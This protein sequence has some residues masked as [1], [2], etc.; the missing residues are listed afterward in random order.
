MLILVAVVLGVVVFLFTAV[1]ALVA[2]YMERKVSAFMQDRLG[3]MEVGFWGFRGGKRFWGGIAQTLADTFKLLLKEDIIPDKSDR[4]LF[5]LGPFILYGA[6]FCAFI[7][8]PLGYG[9]AISDFNIGIFYVIA[10]S[11]VGVIGIILS[12]W[13]SNN[14]WSLYG[15]VRSAAQIISYELPVGMSL[16]LVVMVVGSLQFH[17]IVAWQEQHRWFL[18]HSPFTIVAFVIFFLSGVAEANRTPFDI[19]EAESELVAGYMTEYSGFRWAIFFLSEYA[20]MAVISLMTA[21]VFLG[22]WLSPVGGLLRLF[23]VPEGWYYLDGSLWGVFWISAK[24]ILFI[25][26]MMWFRWTWPRLR[27]DQLMY[28]A[29]KVFLPIALLNIFFVGIWELIFA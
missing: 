1:N 22:G 11:S 9:M 12:G 14:K 24:A 18:F 10:I 17:D 13:G 27:V 19:P 26:I 25:F 2:V 7:G 20:N 6:V 23:G 8:I 4:K 3:P 16:L 28:T 5:I 21:I 15:A 29:W